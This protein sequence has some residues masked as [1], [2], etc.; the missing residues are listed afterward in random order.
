MESRGKSREASRE[1]A[2]R[3]SITGSADSH[4]WIPASQRECEVR[5]EGWRRRK[6]KKKGS[7]SKARGGLE[8]GHH[9]VVGQLLHHLQAPEA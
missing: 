3:S 6:G 7:K 5:G 4:V 1:S 8:D 2:L 9:V